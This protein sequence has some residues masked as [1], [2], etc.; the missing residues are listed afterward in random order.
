MGETENWQEI[1]HNNFEE[2]ASALGAYLPNLVGA[3]LLIILGIALA[4][5]IRWIILR[6]GQGADKLGQRIGVSRHYLNMRWPPSR[7]LA[8]V[9]YWLILIFF[10]TTAAK[11]LELP[12]IDNLIEKLISSLPD[13]LVSVVIIW[14]GFVLGAAVRERM[15]VTLKNTEIQYFNAFGNSARIIIIVLAIVVSLRQIGVD[16]VLIEQVLIVCL[17]SFSLAMSLAFGLGAGTIVTNIIAIN[18]LKKVYL[19]GQRVRVDNLEGQ[20][21]EFLKSA[22]VLDTDT[23]RAMIPARTFQ[24]K[25]SILLDE[26]EAE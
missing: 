12:G 9:F 1:L 23:G 8:G 25:A 18:Q 16:V 19:K 4:W 24:E 20:I 21:L 17:A 13:I 6:L 22:V 11:T 2:L 15:I 3:A 7:V 26:E 14:A 10:L 5:I